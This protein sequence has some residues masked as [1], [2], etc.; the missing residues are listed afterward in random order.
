MSSFLVDKI[1]KCD[2]FVNKEGTAGMSFGE[3]LKA[4]RVMAGLSQED[5]AARISNRITKQAISKYEKDLMKPEGSSTLIAMAGALQVPVDY[6]FRTVSREPLDAHFRKR[7]AVRAKP[8][9]AVTEMVR[10]RLERYVE[11]EELLGIRSD[12]VSPL[13][14]EELGA[15]DDSLGAARKLRVAWGI[16]KDQPV[17]SVTQL[18]EDKGIKLITVRGFGGF[19]GMAGYYRNHPFI[20]IQENFPKERIRFTLLHELAHLLLWDS[21]HQDDKQ[22]EKLC[23]LFASEFLLPAHVLREELSWKIRHSVAIPELLQLKEKYGISM[24]A[25]LFR[26]HSLSL[27]TDAGYKALLREFGARGWRRN[28]PGEYPGDERPIRFERL[29][30]RAISEDVISLSKA[31]ALS[32]LPIVEL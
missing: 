31:A 14:R 22:D 15:E 17:P 13:R 32:L 1:A 21:N 20:S 27:L 9:R 3:R 23:H 24:Q 16:G 4:A 25:I 26:A 19:D 28:E 11:L 29:L 18:F 6:F 30:F 10:D 7:A 2:I 5:L 12:F 8:V